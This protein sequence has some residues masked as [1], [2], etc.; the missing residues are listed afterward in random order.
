VRLW[1]S[2]PPER[3]RIDEIVLPGTLDAVTGEPIVTSAMVFVEYATDVDPSA[4]LG[5]QQRSEDSKEYAAAIFLSRHLAGGDWRKSGDVKDE[6]TAEGISERTLQRVKLELGIEDKREGFPS[7]TYWRHPQ[8][9]HPLSQNGG[10]TVETAWLSENNGVSAPV[11]PAPMGEGA[12]GVTVGLEAS[13][14]DL[15]RFLEGY[16]DAVDRSLI[17]PAES[18]QLAMLDVVYERAGIS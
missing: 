4:V 7:I 2:R 13:D 14:G 12:V 18:I 1:G 15:T 3:H 16:S 11:A 10:A 17:T 6:A 5:A 9:R 8:S